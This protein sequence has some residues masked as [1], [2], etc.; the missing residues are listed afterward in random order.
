MVGFLERFDPVQV[1]YAGHEWR[2]VVEMVAKSAR[3]V[4]KVRYEAA[5]SLASFG[6]AW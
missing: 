4:S 3:A 6:I 2:R 5:E 1:R